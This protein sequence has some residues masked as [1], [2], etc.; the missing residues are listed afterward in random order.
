MRDAQRHVLAPGRGDDLHADR[1][2]RQRHRH[3]DDRQADEGDRLRVNAEIGAHRQ[4][5][6]AEHERL[7]AD[8][9]RRARRRRRQDGVDLVEQLQHL[10]AIPAAE[11]LRLAPTSDAGDHGAGDQPVAHGGSKSCGARAQPVQMQAGALAGGDDEG[12]RA[13]ARRPAGISM[14]RLAPS[15]AGD[16]GRSRT[17]ASGGSGA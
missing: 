5:V 6:V 3:G 12:G 10:V 4:F 14:S 9:R 13:R 15:A 7:L 16:R 11:F 1:Q 17:A 2:R 8:Q